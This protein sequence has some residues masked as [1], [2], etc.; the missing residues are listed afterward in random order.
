M[1]DGT[2]YHIT[3]RLYFEWNAKLNSGLKSEK[4]KK[5]KKISTFVVSIHIFSVFSADDS[6]S[7][8]WQF[9]IAIFQL[10]L[11]FVCSFCS[12]ESVVKFNSAMSL[13]LSSLSFWSG[14]FRSYIWTSTK[15][16]FSLKS[17]TEWHGLKMY[18][19]YWGYPSI[20]NY[21]FFFFF[22]FFFFFSFFQLTF[23]QIWLV[24]E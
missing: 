15:W 4:K 24:L 6:T 20:I 3:L 9:H 17:K 2:F 11:C 16:G 21:H 18:V 7:S 19:W 22:F 8:C 12:R 13:I 5:K 10:Q 14:L 1:F 23:F